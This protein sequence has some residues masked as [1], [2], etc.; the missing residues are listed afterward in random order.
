GVGTMGSALALNMA[1]NGHDVALY[2]LDASTIDALISE[3]GDLAPKLTKCES[4]EALVAIMAPP[5]A[6]MMM[7]PAGGPVEA[8]I[9]A[10]LPHLEPGD[11]IIDGGNSDFRET[12]ARTE[13]VEAAGFRYL[14]IGVS[15]GEEGARHGPSMM[16]GGT[17]SAWEPV[18]PI[19]EAIAAKYD[20][21]PCVAHLGPDGAG[22]FVKTVHNGIEYADMQLIA[23]VYGLLRDGEGRKPAEIAPLYHR[24]NEGA[25][26]SY[27][28]EITG[29]V[30][31]AVD[32]DTGKPVVDIVVD[33]A[34]QKGTGRWTVIEAIRM[35]QSASIIEAAVGARV[36]SSER[37]TRQ[38]AEPI[39][40]PAVAADQGTFDEADLESALLVGRVLAY[41]QGFRILQAASDEFGWELDY[42]RI[43][44]IWRA[45]CIIRS[46][47]LDDIATAFR[48]ELPEGRL[49]LSDHFAPLLKEHIA[50][51]RRVV[52]QATLMG[53]PVQALA[54]AV[55]WFDEI[56][57]ARGTADLI[58]GMRDFFGAHSFERLDKPG[59]FHGPWHS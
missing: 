51:L 26:Q 15:G 58:Q 47:L 42:A 53:L 37:A 56:R 21:D 52:A 41:A 20:G 57:Q 14:G 32:P 13:R 45:G 22:H 33:Q 28:V 24:W 2:N 36:L 10:L 50:P 31:D 38:I 40:A 8:S 1:E 27:L 48:G 35:G 18:A 25:L 59:S 23:E 7:V 5:R 11:T 9:D 49:I 19:Y 55:S 6:I 16:V 34:G 54:S 17:P 44:E 46:S 12:Q 3:A 4:I 39:L 29:K 43:A 30:L